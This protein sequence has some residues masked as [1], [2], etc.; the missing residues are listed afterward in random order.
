MSL[1]AALALHEFGL[2]PIAAMPGSKKPFGQWARWQTE[3]I[4]LRMVREAFGGDPRNIWIPTGGLAPGHI[5]VVDCDS[6]AARALW[7]ERLGS[8][9]DETTCVK[10]ARG[11]QYY[12]RLPEGERWGSKSGGKSA[13]RE[14]WDFRG[15][16]TGVVA[17]P[18][19]HPTG[20]VYEWVR[21]LDSLQDAP[22]ALR[23][24]LY[25]T[26][27]RVSA[28]LN[29]S[30]A[31]ESPLSLAR[32]LK[33]PPGEG[34]RN[35]WLARVAG[36]Y[37]K[38]MADYPAYEHHVRAAAATLEPPLPTDEVAKLLPSIWG[39]EDRKFERAVEEHRFRLRVRGEAEAQERAEDF[40]PP[41]SSFDLT[42]ELTTPDPDVQWL[43]EGL[44]P[45]GGNVVLT[46]QYKTGKSTLALNLL[47]SLADSTPFLG[48]AA[49]YLDGRVAV[50]NREM[51]VA[52][53]RRWL[54]EQGVAHPD[55]AAVQHLRGEPNPLASP[56]GIEWTVAWLSE[57]DV[58]FWILD[59]Y[60]A[61]F[62]GDNESDNSQVRRFLTA[63]DEIKQRAGVAG[64]MLVS[65]TG[66]KEHRHGEEHVRGATVLDDWADA[67]WVLTRDDDRHRYLL[68]EG[69]DVQLEESRLAYDEQTHTY[70]LP[71]ANV[72]ADRGKSRIEHVREA[73]L[74]RVNVE[75]GLNSRELG[76]R[77]GKNKGECAK[78]VADL[79][80]EGHIVV[81]D[82]PNRSKLH[83][84]PR[85]AP[86]QTELEVDS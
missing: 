48:S 10:T 28:G 73:V 21:G 54:R 13:E 57:R 76:D 77:V 16:G 27:E 8:V 32:L 71:E 75:P 7:R 50:W 19:I 44:A 6:D 30:Q 15:D 64:L 17:P 59:T 25:G 46:A 33:N 35:D 70:T 4:A 47:K 68:A 31:A 66:R 74:L 51:P 14:K 67:R 3:R 23:E 81:V 36:H 22:A 18:S 41:G 24:V 84:L 53:Y 38:L 29:G 39:A 55:R 82:G 63:L 83:Y 45:A 37:A 56:E 42:E 5:G 43:V 69:R 65:H 11:H 1:E 61:L 26:H 20:A 72:G 86:A 49:T 85:D 80:R 58:G 34:G 79:R 62:T 9:L 12:F 60:G 78:A 52:M 40:E 2:N